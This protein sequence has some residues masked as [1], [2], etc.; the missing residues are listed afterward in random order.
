MQLHFAAISR[1]KIYSPNHVGNDARILQLTIGQLQKKGHSITVYD[2]DDISRHNLD[3][4]L[5][6]N[7]IRGEKSLHVLQELEAGGALIVNSTDGILNC[8]REN[9]ACLL[10]AAGIPVPQGMVADTAKECPLIPFTAEPFAVWVKRG[11]VHA[12]HREDVTMVHSP[13][14]LSCI[15]REY[16]RR[17][18]RS[19]VIQKN[20]PGPVVKFYA[21]KGTPFFHAYFHD[22]AQKIPFNIDRLKAIAN[23]CART[24]NVDIYGG[25][26]VIT[27]E[28]DIQIIDLNDW[29]S[30]APV[31]DEASVHIAGVI[32]K[33]ARR[34]MKTSASAQDKRLL[35]K[36]LQPHK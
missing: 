8:Y 6:F 20:I 14:E 13:D 32:E 5:I 3:S 7:M 2:E 36:Q 9:L 24:L 18:I 11:D 25:D 31:R 15:L 28:G 4:N 22:P 10:P 21:V 17:G 27:P 16:H 34:H 29:P 33:K 23:L 30:F 35:D 1:G 12:I 19:A 26:A